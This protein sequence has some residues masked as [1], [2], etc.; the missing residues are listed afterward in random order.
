MN[1]CNLLFNS[2]I[3]VKFFTEVL[4]YSTVRHGWPVSLSTKQDSRR[5]VRRPFPPRRNTLSSFGPQ[6]P[7]HTEGSSVRRYEE[8]EG[9]KTKRINAS[10][11]QLIAAGKKSARVYNALTGSSGY[12]HSPP[13]GFGL[14]GLTPV[15][16]FFVEKLEIGACVQLRFLPEI[17]SA[18]HR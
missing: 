18:F 16:P 1:H 12:V 15:D 3:S 8:P 5:G 6:I 2:V 7:P 17:L 11:P 9:L 13:I 10:H 14:V 4:S